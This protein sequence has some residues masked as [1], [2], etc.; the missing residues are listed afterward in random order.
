MNLPFYPRRLYLQ[1][2]VPVMLLWNREAPWL[3]VM[4]SDS[5][6]SATNDCQLKQNVVETIDTV[7]IPPTHTISP[8]LPS[9]FKCQ[10]CMQFIKL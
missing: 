9:T 5:Q 3:V 6:Y 1:V 4:A 10:M 8:E 2:G 7:L